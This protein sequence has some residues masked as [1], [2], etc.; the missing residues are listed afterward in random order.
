MVKVIDCPLCNGGK[1][2]IN[3]A[4][5]YKIITDGYVSKLPLKKYCKNCN[6]NVKYL[7]VHENDYQKMLEFVQSK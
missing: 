1:L 4:N 5:G 6:R 3:V 2:N 7:V